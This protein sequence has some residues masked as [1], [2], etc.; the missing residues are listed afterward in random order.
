VVP[1]PEEGDEEPA[2][3][4]SPARLSVTVG[5]GTKGI[6]AGDLDGD[7]ILDLAE[8][9]HHG[10]SITE[11]LARPPCKEKGASLRGDA[12]SDRSI[13]IEDAVAGLLHMFAASPAACPAAL[14]VDGNGTLEVTDAIAIL[15]NSSSVRA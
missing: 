8:S 14:D 15:W 9:C 3:A 5:D 1:L 6:A 12:N 11:V 2:G 10:K 4:D 7:G 13:D